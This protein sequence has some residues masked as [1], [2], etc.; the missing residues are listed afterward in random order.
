M[1]LNNYIINTNLKLDASLKDI[2]KICDEAIK[3]HLDKV[4]I[5]P[6][7]VPLAIELLKDS[8]V[9]VETAISYPLGQNTTNTK[10]YEA[11]EAVNQK[12]SHIMLVV[13]HAM[14]KNQNYEEVKEEIEEI[15]DSIDGKDLTVLINPDFLEEKEIIK[16]VEICNDTFINTITLETDNDELLE[17]I[18]PVIKEHKIDLLEIRINKDTINLHQLENLVKIGVNYIGTSNVKQIMEEK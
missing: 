3:Y 6:Y 17:K 16:V 11:I 9:I 2:E 18:I 14:I 5:N 7:Y 12:V 4:C 15:R 1:E 13:N 8:N 10:A